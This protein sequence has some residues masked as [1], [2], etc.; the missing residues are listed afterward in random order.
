MRVRKH[1]RWQRPQHTDQRPTSPASRQRLPF[2]RER[3]LVLQG[4]GFQLGHGQR[5]AEVIPLQLL[6]VEC[7]Q[8]LGRGQVFHTFGHD[9]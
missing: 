4:P 6:A 7:T 3:R 9:A 1:Y 2:V 8:H 5:T